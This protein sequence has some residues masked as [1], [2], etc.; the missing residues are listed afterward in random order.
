MT[1]RTGHMGY[2]FCHLAGGVDAPLG[3][4]WHRLSGSGG[5]RVRLWRNVYDLLPVCLTGKVG[6]ICAVELPSLAD[7]Y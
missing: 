2:T 3:D 7:R 5:E 6:V 4:A 1:E